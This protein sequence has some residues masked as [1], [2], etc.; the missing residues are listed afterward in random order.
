MYW[1]QPK[2][3]WEFRKD[4]QVEWSMFS[5]PENSWVHP[6]FREWWVENT[7]GE[8]SYELTYNND[9]L[10]AIK[11]GSVELIGKTLETYMPAFRYV[12]PAELGTIIEAVK[13]TADKITSN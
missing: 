2:A 10:S 8:V 5:D 13:Y 6:F 12:T 1:V 7:V 3:K 4:E 9:F 11:T